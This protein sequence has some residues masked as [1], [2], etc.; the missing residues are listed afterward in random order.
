MILYNYRNYSL[1]WKQQPFASTLKIRDSNLKILQSCLIKMVMGL[2][3]MMM[4]DMKISNL[5]F[6]SDV[7]KV[8]CSLILLVMLRWLIVLVKIYPCPRLLNYKSYD[9]Y[10]AIDDVRGYFS[11]FDTDEVD[12]IDGVDAID[13][14]DTVDT[15]DAIDAMI[16]LLLLGYGGDAIDTNDRLVFC[17]SE[18]YLKHGWLLY[19]LF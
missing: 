13:T 16:Q 11:C 1:L 19:C 17:E 5:G 12:T 2:C 4:I 15:I 3:F 7:P 9:L 10:Y 18:S 8:I 6:C 14:V